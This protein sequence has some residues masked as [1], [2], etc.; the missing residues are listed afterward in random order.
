[1]AKD[2]ATLR[3]DLLKHLEAALAI[4]DETAD[5][6]VGYHVERA[7]DELRA[8]MLPGNLDVP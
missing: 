5:G 7:L 6:V 2:V 1:M 4:A 3:E 8:I